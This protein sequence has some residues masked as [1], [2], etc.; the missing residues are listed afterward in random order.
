[1]DCGVL[2][3]TSTLSSISWTWA[4]IAAILCS[5]TLMREARISVAEAGGAVG[6]EAGGAVAGEAG[7]AIS[8]TGESRTG[9]RGSETGEGGAPEEVD[10]VG[11]RRAEGGANTGLGPL[12]GGS[13][14]ARGNHSTSRGS[15]TRR[16]PR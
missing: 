3:A 14:R 7:A 2:R 12:I 11:E 9:V 1:M 4:G 16:S 10:G 15:M 6:G 13:E 5:M 8:R